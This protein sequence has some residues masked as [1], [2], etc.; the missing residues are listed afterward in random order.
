MIYLPEPEQPD[1]GLGGAIF[2]AW[3]LK[4]GQREKL[5]IAKK[6][7]TRILRRDAN[8]C[9][10]DLED[11]IARAGEERLYVARLSG[12]EYLVLT[13]EGIK[14][15]EPWTLY[16]NVARGHHGQPTKRKID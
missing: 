11:F 3:L 5:S 13:K 1:L 4:I 15:A 8:L 16:Y 9:E 14:W 10:M 2:L 7:W 12:E 6:K